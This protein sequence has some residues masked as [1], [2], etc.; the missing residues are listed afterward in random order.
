MKNVY[1][2]L[3]VL[4]GLF[5]IVQNVS[6]EIHASGASSTRQV[7]S[8]KSATNYGSANMMG[9][10]MAMMGEKEKA[11][12]KSFV[13]MFIRYSL[14]VKMIER[15]SAS[16]TS[17]GG[18]VVVFGNRVTKYDKDMN[19]VKE[20]DMEVDLESMDRTISDLS[21]KYADEAMKLL[22]QSMS[23]PSVVASKRSA[24]DA[25][26]KATARAMSTASESYATA[27]NGNY[28]SAVADLTNA[29]PP[30]L[31][32]NYCGQEISGYVYSCEF[33]NTGYKFTATPQKIGETGT[34]AVTITTGGV[35]N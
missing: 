3:A 11:M 17:D 33:S 18:A 25:L 35:M 31:N 12:M 29:T 28:P 4:V 24:N 21:Q 16:A 26:A 34:T 10:G 19:V 1:I 20:V 30:Y 22:S 6:A 23:M 32:Q 27:N 9:A 13:E 14:T 8:N 5:S 2:V 15:S 7:Y